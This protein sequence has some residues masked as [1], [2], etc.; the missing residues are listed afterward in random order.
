[1]F[2]FCRH[3]DKRTVPALTLLLAMAAA[4]LWPGRLAAQC[5]V[6]TDVTG[7]IV[8]HPP[9]SDIDMIYDSAG[10]RCL[11][12]DAT[13][14]GASVVLSAYNGQAWSAISAT[15]DV[16]PA[17]LYGPVWMYD[18]T[19]NVALLYG[20]ELGCIN[21]TPTTN[22][23]AFSGN[24]W[25]RLTWAGPSPPG[26]ACGT[27][28]SNRGRAIVL[29]ASSST[30]VNYNETWE[31][32]GDHWEQGPMLGPVVWDSFVFDAY[33]NI[34]FLYG[35]T[36]D[37]WEDVWFYRPGATA[38]ESRWERQ[39]I[40]GTPYEARIHTRLVYDP[41]RHWVLR[42]LGRYSLN[43]SYVPT[44]DAW[45]FSASTWTRTIYSNY[46]PDSARRSTDG[47][48]Y[49]SNRDVIV[50]S[51]GGRV[52]SGGTI[53][54]FTDT[55]EQ[56]NAAPGFS[57]ISP[58]LTALCLGSA[59]VLAVTAVGDNVGVSWFH[60]GQLVP[61]ATGK[62]LAFGQLSWTDDGNYVARLSSGCGT[63]DTP[64][65]RL[66]VDTPIL[67]DKVS[68]WPDCSQTCPG[69]TVHIDP[70]VPIDFTIPSAAP[71]AIHLQ[72]LVSGQWV[73]VRV[74][75]LA[76]PQNFDFPN[77]QPDFSGD[78]RFYVDG[79]SCPGRVE[80]TGHIQVGI[81]VD[82][83]P[84]SLFEVSPCTD[85]S[86][87]VSAQGGCGLSYTWMKDG[88]ALADNDRIEGGNTPKLTVH[89]VRYGDEGIY[90]C[91]LVD[92]NQCGV[93]AFSDLAT[94]RLVTPPWVEV[95]MN[96]AP[97][98][99]QTPRGAWT[100]AFD[101]N[102]GVLVMYGGHSFRGDAGN[103][104]WEYD[105]QTWKAIQDSYSNLGVTSTG[106]QLF[107]NQWPP[108]NY[109]MVYNPD[110]KLIYLFG[111][112][113][114][115]WPMAVWTWDGQTWKRPYYGPVPAGGENSY[116]AVYD[117]AR[118]KILFT[119][120]H[121]GGYASELWVYDPVANSFTGPTVMQ[122]P[123]EYGVFQAFWV[124]DERR[125]V[126]FWYQDDGVGYGPPT[127]WAYDTQW[128]KLAGKPIQFAPWGF[129]QN[130][131]YDPVRGHSTVLGGGWVDNNGW[132]TTTRAFPA[133]P[134]P[135][136]PRADSWETV[137]PDGPPRNFL[138]LGLSPTNAFTTEILA[139]DRRR[140]ALVAAGYLNASAA[141]C[142]TLSWATYESRYLDQ[143]QIDVQPAP[144]SVPVGATAV[145]T[146]RAAGFGT[147]GYQWRHAG[148]L[149]TDGPGG[150]AAGGGSV[151]GAT[152][153]TLTIVGVAASDLGNYDLLITNLC[154]S[155]TSVPAQ[156]GSIDPFQISSPGITSTNFSCQFAG[157]PG[158]T[159]TLKSSPNPAGPWQKVTNLTLPAS[160]VLPFSEPRAT[161]QN[162]FYRL[163]YP[164]E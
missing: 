88:I 161:N 150:A 18:S 103:S 91:W 139:F 13:P 149:V 106:Q 98:E 151:S 84:V 15:G 12:L 144:V 78:Y 85:A 134:N 11:A 114:W 3:T 154:G 36:T 93:S 48:A 50:I 46:L 59:A 133:D 92:S 57:A 58:P 23:Y 156:L 155:A 75:T 28:D 61:G 104:M 53:V 111:E 146:A 49:D 87:A 82:A 56:H 124:Y 148:Q 55:W 6:T 162:R 116:R 100:S 131:V 79:S 14:D 31:W 64:V 157:S 19:R 129:I 164:P 105:G 72:K 123:L 136:L 115:H 99:V 40:T 108:N 2:D 135:W 97:P 138:A 109:S 95:Q 5:V 35:R 127:A 25:R 163:S 130:V 60:N 76:A 65:M 101:E 47:I 32:T 71:L 137:L 74:S 128:T 43:T 22:I 52:D 89:R 7:S 16:P 142:P 69:T 110:D 33:H 86:F 153:P 102:R 118:H 17:P 37:G 120:S 20:G 113:G 126:S 54:T 24:T 77:V 26:A 140:R 107:D 94:L 81:R 34:G 125:Q 27:F 119:R 145:L 121:N 29:A 66:R 143:V 132:D 159:F 117:R 141:C 158:V 51:G 38:A 147:L 1:M 152:T 90:S 63:I 67:F 42:C 41:Y 8:G 10:Q 30:P 62:L 112:G 9:S 4:A 39:T 68:S 21:C 70:P 96:P 45:D 122:P 160:G 73:D 83:Q 44:I 80:K